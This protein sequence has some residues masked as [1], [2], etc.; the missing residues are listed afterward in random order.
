[1]SALK[2]KNSKMDPIIRFFLVMNLIVCFFNMCYSLLFGN[3]GALANTTIFL[4][5]PVLYLFFMTKC[6]SI[7]VIDGLVKVIIYGGLIVLAENIIFFGNNFFLNSGLIEELGEQLG[8]R[9][10]IYDGF[11]EYYSPSQSYLPY[12]LYFS[13][14][15]LLVPH[16]RIG[17]E[18][19]WLITMAI[20][21]AIMI[22]I[23]GRRAM[24]L[25]LGLLPIYL[26]CI[27]KICK[28]QG[29]SILKILSLCVFVGGILFFALINFF[30]LDFMT[31]EL[32]SA[33]D[34]YTNDSNL[35]RVLQNKSLMN[36]F[37]SSPIIGQG[38]GFVSAYVRT[39]DHPWEYELVYQYLLAS[40]GL[41]GMAFLCIPFMW[42]LNKSINIVKRTG[43]YTELIIPAISGLFVFLIIN[44][45][46]PYLLKFDF[47]WIFFLPI[48]ILN[49]IRVETRNRK[50]IQ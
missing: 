50:S 30:D 27:L 4:I 32:L 41:V 36:D 29:F 35:E 14:S 37:L 43:S 10:G 24:W 47:L 25:T 11:T 42:I 6:R 13:S 48:I 7:S 15:M 46:N 44:A 16:S 18:D 26:M 45:T 39:P 2:I 12:F 21:S 19:K 1:M 38:I 3:P 17:V 5:W 34:M 49:Q 31:V 33:F 28:L 23:S 20:A 8:F 22:L 9:Y 40:F